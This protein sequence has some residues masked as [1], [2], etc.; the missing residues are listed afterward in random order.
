MKPKIIVRYLPQF[1]RTKEN[2]EWWGEGFT[3]W[4]TV[5]KG[6]SLYNGHLQPR[7]PL[8]G[9]YYNLLDKNTMKWQADLARKYGIDGFA[10]YHYWFKDGKQILE[11]PAENLLKW[12]DIDMPFCFCWANETWSRTWS[13][14]MN[15]NVWAGEF[16]QKSECND[17][18]ILLDQKYGLSGAWI[19]HIKYLI[20][21]FQDKRYI[22]HNGKPVFMIYHPEEMHCLPD[23]EQL[24]EADQWAREFTRKNLTK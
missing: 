12:K 13:N 4:T 8:N 7:E 1:H 20:P 15:G 18:G 21:F 16:E 2:D 14:L 19:D 24:L 5:R 9:N 11:R 10:F 23:M 3:E 6:K 17:N 22:K